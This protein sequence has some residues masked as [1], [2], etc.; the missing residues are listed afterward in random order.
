M[1]EQIRLCPDGSW[2]YAKRGSMFF[3]KGDYRKAI[4]DF[5]EALRLNPGNPGFLVNRALAYEEKR[6]LDKAIADATELIRLNSSAKPPYIGQ[7]GSRAEPYRVRAWAFAQKGELDKALADAVEAVRLDPNDAEGFYVR[8]Y[9]Y[10]RKGERDKAAADF[11]A[12]ARLDAN[13]GEPKLSYLVNWTDEVKNFLLFANL[14]VY[15]SLGDSG[16]REDLGLS[17][18]QEKRLR[19]VATKF[20]AEQ[21]KF[22]DSLNKLP[23]KE[24]EAKREEAGK[25]ENWRKTIEPV[26]KRVERILTPEQ[27][28]AFKKRVIS[29]QIFFMLADP[30]SLATWIGAS[31]EQ[32]EKLRRLADDIDRRLG[33]ELERQN[34]ELLAALDARQREVVGAEIEQQL[35]GSG[36]KNYFCGAVIAVGTLTLTGTSAYSTSDSSTSTSGGT[37]TVISGG[38]LNLSTNLSAGAGDYTG[39]TTV[40][41]GTASGSGSLSLSGGTDDAA[42]GAS[43]CLPVYGPLLQKPIRNR[44]GMSKA[45]QKKLLEIATKFQAYQEKRQRRRGSRNS[46]SSTSRSTKRQ[47]APC[48]SKSRPC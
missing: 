41:S 22:E 44:L 38:T 15:Q 14:P 47:P 2:Y 4:A 25:W 7:Y 11:A 5:T 34:Q 12:A 48:A 33:R 16:L 36:G 27:F 8:G 30:A 39:P 17:P 45:Q 29:Q 3:L 26:R 28:G 23:Q 46:P 35:C 40:F 43:M 1:T 20:R 19:E 32:S 24:Q 21:G 31:R 9:V 6:D 10:G 13:G 18:E 42:E 37:A